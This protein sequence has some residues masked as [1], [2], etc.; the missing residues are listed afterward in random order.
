MKNLLRIGQVCNLYGISLDTLRY[1]DRKDLLKPI[2]DKES[3]YRYYS[4]E[5]L[6]VLEMLLVGKYLE[7]PLEQM[8]D[9]IAHESIGEYLAMIEEQHQLIEER[10][11]LLEKLSVYT[12]EMTNVLRKISVF[13][14]DYTFTNVTAEKDLD[15]TIYQVNLKDL[16]HNDCGP[17]SNGIEAFE[18]W[19]TYVVNE[20]GK[21]TADNQTVGLS[22]LSPVFATDTLHDSMDSM[23][24]TGRASKHCLSGKY[25]YIGFWGKESGLTE[26]LEL[27]CCHF[28]LV[29]PIL[30]VK[31]RF[32]LLH[33][34]M[35]HEYFAEIY[36]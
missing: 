10:R 5:H 11:S 34:D 1:Y 4:L 31:F 30:S 23:V 29:N 18:Q 14:N 26:Y 28:K 33:D 27:I 20:E 7:I 22:I 2:V 15:V 36:F 25:Q 16:F 17:K 8:R 3:G 32:A 13:E 6:D 24:L 9:K 19:V 35:E 21:L 12:E